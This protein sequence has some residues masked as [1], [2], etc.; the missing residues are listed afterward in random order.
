MLKG[1]DISHHNK[2]M[3]NKED[4]KQFDFVFMK[5][6]EGV[7]FKDYSIYGYC[8]ALEGSDTVKG[9]YHF[10]RPEKGNTPKAEALNFLAAIK[11]YQKDNPLIA[12]D[13]EAGALN[14]NA[15]DEWC[16]RWCLYVYA[17]L[18]YKPII[19]CSE[20]ETKRFKKCAEW[21][22]G[23]W[24]AKWGSKKPTSIKPWPFFAFWQYTSSGAFSGVRVD[25]DYFNGKR[26]QLLKYCEVINNEESESDNPSHY[27]TD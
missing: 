6:S 12:L 19:Y 13:V 5:A 14:F 25:L 18:G 24:V 7:S 9:F 21:G 22:A 26:E 2:N 8:A 15:L 27:T 23:L 11:R 4:L 20:S 3:K 1:I 16:L 17:Q 10:A